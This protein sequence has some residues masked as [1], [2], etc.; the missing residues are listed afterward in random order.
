MTAERHGDLGQSVF[1][2]EIGAIRLE[3]AKCKPAEIGCSLAVRTKSLLVLL[4]A[5]FENESTGQISA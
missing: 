5:L 4:I 1:D 2:A 3:M